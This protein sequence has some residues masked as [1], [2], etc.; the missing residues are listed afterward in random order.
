TPL[1]AGGAACLWQSAPTYSAMQ[2]RHAI[3]MS[4]DQWT[5]PDSLK[6][7]GIPDYCLSN[8]I[9]SDQNN[10]LN[11]DHFSVS[12][13]PNNGE[14]TFS[15]SLSE[16]EKGSIEI[17]DATGKLVSMFAIQ[18]GEKNIRVNSSDLSA[19]IYFC[20]FVVNGEM[21]SSEKISVVK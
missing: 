19:G 17:F 13:N 4:S 7:Y 6:G 18:S 14:M 20:R 8:I 2:L 9:L 15:V 16:G 5:A 21:M 12:P 10:S 3:Q 1:S 11:A